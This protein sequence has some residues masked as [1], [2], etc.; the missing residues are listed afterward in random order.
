MHG[1]TCLLKFISLLKVSG[2]LGVYWITLPNRSFYISEEDC[3]VKQSR[4]YMRASPLIVFLK[5]TGKNSLKLY[6]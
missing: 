6:T 3:E 1:Y 5:F 2:E 4:F